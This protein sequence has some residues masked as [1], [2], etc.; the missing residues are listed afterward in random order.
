M[1]VQAEFDAFTKVFDYVKEQPILLR[2]KNN[3]ADKTAPT[4]GS[5]S[6]WKRRESF[7]TVGLKRND[8]KVAG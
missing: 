1:I 3:R 5:S 2:A 6:S 4:K 7:S 8:F